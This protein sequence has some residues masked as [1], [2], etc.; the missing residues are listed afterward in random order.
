MTHLSKFL[1][2]EYISLNVFGTNK[3][4]VFAIMQ[5]HAVDCA[6]QSNHIVFIAT[7]CWQLKFHLN[8]DI[9]VP[10]MPIIYIFK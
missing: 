2:Q 4:T 5:V 7:S 10:Y 6:Q 1:T 8:L 3:Y 9:L